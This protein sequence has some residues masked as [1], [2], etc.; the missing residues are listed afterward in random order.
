MPMNI[1]PLLLVATA[2]KP[3]SQGAIDLPAMR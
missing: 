1:K 2:D 3:A